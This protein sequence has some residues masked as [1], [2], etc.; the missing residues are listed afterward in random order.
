MDQRRSL[1]RVVEQVAVTDDGLQTIG[2][3]LGPGFIPWLTAAT[4]PAHLAFY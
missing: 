3:V 2:R 1:L 4:L